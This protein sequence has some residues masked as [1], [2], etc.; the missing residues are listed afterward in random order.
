MSEAN[1]V[2]ENLGM[3]VAF[4]PDLAIAYEPWLKR[5][6][7]TVVFRLLQSSPY[8]KKRAA[9][10]QRAAWNESKLLHGCM[11]GEN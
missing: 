6:K 3:A 10:T 4:S 2:K 7:A 5:L 8:D 11:H 9:G 1:S